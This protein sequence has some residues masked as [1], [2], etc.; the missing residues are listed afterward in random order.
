MTTPG[1]PERSAW[2][3]N[4]TQVLSY[5]ATDPERRIALPS[6]RFTTPGGAAS[7]LLGLVLM[8]LLY[9]ISWA[10][11]GTEWGDLVWKYLTGFSGIP[12]PIALLSC[13]SASILL[14]KALKIST[15]R[16]A[17]RLRFMPADPG[18]VL[19]VATVDRVIDSIEQGVDEPHRFLLLD[20]VLTALKSIRNIG[21]IGDLDEMLN[22][23]AEADDDAMDSGYT[24]V[25]GF[26]W[27]IP[28]LG[29]I[30]TIIGLTEAI[31]GFGSVLQASDA[32]VDVLTTS[33][34]EVIAG[35]DTAFVTT[36]EGLIAALILHLSLTF[37]RRSDERLLDDC[38]RYAARNITAHVRITP[39][40]GA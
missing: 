34:T 13:W 25:R 15:Q 5:A 39:D 27:A 2:T 4:T 1:Q 26:I 33:L 38:R 29:F 7:I 3:G 17:L 36:G 21:R 12:I 22:S 30:G 6:G 37:V 20:R 24:V 11:R 35:L 10:L 14:L 8:G 28:V 40:A 19:S 18:F 32:T 23:A 9:G 31:S 16:T